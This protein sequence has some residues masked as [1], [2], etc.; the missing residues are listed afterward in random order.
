MRCG[1]IVALT[2]KNV[3]VNVTCV[4]DREVAARCI[5]D[6][7]ILAVGGEDNARV[8][9]KEMEKKTRRPRGSGCACGCS[10]L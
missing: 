10:L 9:A 8:Y 3:R 6:G 1:E 7:C 2:T 4:A 5:C